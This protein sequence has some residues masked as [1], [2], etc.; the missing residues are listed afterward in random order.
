MSIL[1]SIHQCPNCSRVIKFST[2]HTTVSVCVCG[3][4]LNRM[5]DGSIIPRP[6][7]TVVN[8]ADVIAPGTT[9]QWNGKPFTI[10]GR[11]RTWGDETVFSY[12]TILFQDQ[13]F[14]YLL[15]GYGM[16]SICL[17]VDSPPEL[18]TDVI[19]NMKPGHNKQMNGEKYMMLRNDRCLRW[20]VEGECYLPECS[21]TFITYDFSSASG[22]M[23]HIIEYWPRVQPAFEVHHT[24]F[25]SLALQ[26]TRAFTTDGNTFKCTNCQHEIHVATFPYAQ[27]CA[28]SSCGT[29]YVYE[30][31]LRFVKVAG[32][33][34]KITPDIPIG[35]TGTIHGISYKI[36]G[37]IVKEERNKYRSRWR[38]YT[39]FNEREGY[40][41]L[42]EFDG[43]WMYLREQGKTPVPE[44]MNTTGYNYEGVNYDLFNSYYYN[45]VYALGEFAANAFDDGNIKCQEFI[46][47]PTLWAREQ[48]PKEGIVWFKGWHVERSD[49]RAT[50]GEAINM[51]QQVG[52]GAVEPNGYVPL[53]KLFTG[54]LIGIAVLIIIHLLA[55]SGSSNRQILDK[56]FFFN[57]S[58]GV[59][60]A[61]IGDLHLDKRRSN[62]KLVLIAPIKNTWM[63]LEATLVNKKTGAE[64][65]VSKGIE[66]YEGVEDGETWTEG[67]H[68]AEF[69]INEIPE[70]DYTLQLTAQREKGVGLVNY[71]TISAFYD[72]SGVRN[73][74]I[75]IGLLLLWPIFKFLRTYFSERKRWENSPYSRFISYGSDN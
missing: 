26:H 75:C 28:C 54:T 49:L 44:D 27:S 29:L 1:P 70:G 57:D 53:R 64:Y 33:K 67:S 20:E 47:P 25:N 51:P 66:Y 73:L 24:D 45:V 23:L 18:K 62:V 4:V 6:F 19:K 36:V 41:F 59:Q 46:S 21:S 7:A 43:H 31:L 58:S 38:E 10:T 61:V 5:G 30:D 65:S 69:Y 15:E 39:L 13:S 35:T 32:G 52:T 74:F 3:T 16:Y 14:A 56:D 40:A 60:T 11:F 68:Q 12:W 22:K 48:S 17:P 9:G 2:P 71:Y 37:F 63:E 50:F 8:T 72:V 34:Q 55:S 42:S